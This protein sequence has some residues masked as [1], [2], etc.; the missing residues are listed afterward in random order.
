MVLYGHEEGDRF[1]S[2][3]GFA[4]ELD[5]RKEELGSLEGL[6]WNEGLWNLNWR[7]GNGDRGLREGGEVSE[8]DVMMEA[9]HRCSE[10]C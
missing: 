2:A 3:C 10:D 4:W 1:F 7:R 9:K 6:R 8:L 5:G